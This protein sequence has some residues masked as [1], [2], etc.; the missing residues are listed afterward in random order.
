MIHFFP[1]NLHHDFF[2]AQEQDTLNGNS[3][4]RVNHIIVGFQ[5]LDKEWENGQKLVLGKLQVMTMMIMLA[6]DP[7]RLLH[8]HPYLTTESVQVFDSIHFENR[9]TSIDISLQVG[10]N[11]LGKEIN[12]VHKL[13]GLSNTKL[14]G[15]SARCNSNEQKDGSVLGFPVGLRIGIVFL[16][17]N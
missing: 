13:I 8:Q 15:G 3:R 4:V 7:F 14:H 9:H 17:E 5:V 2:L 12:N 1:I 16:K 10:Q 11:V 6:L